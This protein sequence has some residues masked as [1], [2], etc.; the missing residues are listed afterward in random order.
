MTGPAVYL[1][2]M[3]VVIL[4]SLAGCELTTP[5]QNGF[6][7]E[8][9]ALAKKLENQKQL[10]DSQIQW[11]ILK[12]MFPDSEYVTQQAQQ[13]SAKID[14]R[15]DQLR[16]QLN[17]GSGESLSSKDRI[18]YL[19]ILSL[20]PGNVEAREALQKEEWSKVELAATMK[21]EKIQRLFTENQKKAKKEIDLARFK[22][23]VKE[24]LQSE[25]YVSL[26]KLTETFLKDFPD[27]QPA[28]QI[29]YNALVGIANNH[30]KAGRKE[31]A[32]TYYEQAQAVNDLNSESL[33]SKI[34]QLREQV[35][36]DFYLL[37]MKAFKTNIDK[38]VSLLQKSV[39]VNPQNHRARQQ[40]T[41]ATKIQKNLQKIKQAS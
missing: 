1:R 33:D 15:V 28:Y 11:N 10:A 12:E 34:G 39:E 22:Q 5:K 36:N 41:R 18:V 13:L 24:L 7:D 14:K 16:S 27:Y 2:L 31:E 26:I 35:S 23:E 21:T 4:F 29:K 25:K 9:V 17:H 40:L 32:I 3:F 38:A 37:G 8:R 6:L 30:L 20:Q 19:K